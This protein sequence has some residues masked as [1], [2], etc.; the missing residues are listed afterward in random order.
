YGIWD[1]HTKDFR[2]AIANTN[3]ILMELAQIK[4]NERILD[5]GCGVGGTAM[6]LCENRDVKVTGIT[7][8]QKQLNHAN[9][10]AQ[11]RGFSHRADF[12]VMDYTQT[13][14]EDASFDVIWCCESVCHAQNPS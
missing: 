14:F 2:S 1:Q 5:A 4:N 6:F 3:R 13:G 11:K 9:A 7:L 12:H 8:S 10:L